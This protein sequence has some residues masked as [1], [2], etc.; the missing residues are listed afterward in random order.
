MTETQSSEAKQ[1]FLQHVFILMQSG[2]IQLGKIMNPSTQKIEK[3]LEG[4]KR[5]IDL[6]TMLRE[7]TDGNLD[8]EEREMLVNAI[9]SLQLNYVDEL[10]TKNDSVGE[11][12]SELDTE[13]ESTESD[14]EKDR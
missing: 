6:L 9:S 11:S 14:T 13:T 4:T 5:I 3:D 12:T 2:M 10:K 8:D 7:K 1:I